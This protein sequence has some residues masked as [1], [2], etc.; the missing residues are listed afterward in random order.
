MVSSGAAAGATDK[1]KVGPAIPVAPSALPGAPDNGNGGFGDALSNT[2]DSAPSMGSI[3]SWVMGPELMLTS[4]AAAGA[5]DKMRVGAGAGIRVAPS[6]LT[7]APDD[8]NGGMGAELSNTEDSTPVGIIDGGVKGPEL[9]VSSGAAAGATDNPKV[10]AGAGIRVAPSA[11]PGAPD[12][13]GN[14]GM[15]AE[16]SDTEED[17]TPVGTIVGWV[18]GPE[19]MVSSGAAVGA[20][21]KP[22]VGA[23]IPVASS[24]LPDAPD[25]GNGGIGAELSKIEDS[26]PVGIIDGWVMGPELMV[27]SSAAA[28]ATDKTKVGA[29]A[30]IRVAPSALPG[31]PDDDGNG[32]M[33]AELSDTEE[34][35]TPVGTIVGWDM[36]PELMVSSGAAAGATDKPK[37]GAGIPVVDSALPI[38]TDDVND[39]IGA[40][41][42][43][44][45]S[46]PVGAIVGWLIGASDMC[47]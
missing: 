18:M 28:G 45:E 26:A 19:L 24:T 35:S 10:G 21:D 27:P 14:G 1:P 6:A 13:D 2:E 43:K 11:L 20:T 22:E 40:E 33:G 38:A 23:G 7:G 44:M 46:A 30:G 3:D 39:G 17:S 9:M 25:D 15:G 41:L 16:L 31:A 4:G 29:G 47:P 42:R 5:T 36:G 37:V 8:G 12:D 32:G 34:D